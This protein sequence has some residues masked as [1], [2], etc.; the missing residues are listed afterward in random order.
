ME[1][2][3]SD[4]PVSLFDRAEGSSHGIGFASSPAPHFT[5]PISKE[6]CLLAQPHPNPRLVELTASEVRRVNS[7][8]ITR[9]DGQLYAPFNIGAV[10]KLFDAVSSQTGKQPRRVLLKQWPCC[11]R[12]S[13]MADRGSILIR[14]KLILPVPAIATPTGVSV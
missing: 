1:F 8:T 6:I 3:R 2:L 14:I 7:G 5:F 9:A 11:R 13:T 10:K 12:G 4:N